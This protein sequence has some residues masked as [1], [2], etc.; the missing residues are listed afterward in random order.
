MSVK[1]QEP[2][3]NRSLSRAERRQIEAAVA[4]ARQTDKKKQS[5][6]DSIPFQRMFPDGICRV[7]ESYYTK[8]VQFESGQTPAGARRDRHSEQ[9]QTSRRNSR[10]SERRGSPAVVSR[11]LPYGRAGAVP[12]FVGLAG[13]FRP[14][15]QGL[16]RPQLFRIQKR[17]HVRHGASG[18]RSQLPANPRAGAE[19]PNAG[20]F[21]RHGI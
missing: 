17:Q 20:R 14:I 16:R 18:R 6:Q 1:R 5:A 3:I 7:T 4:K 8:T 9:F 15:R 10:I 21:S 2:A 12:L 19:R 11:H 13:P